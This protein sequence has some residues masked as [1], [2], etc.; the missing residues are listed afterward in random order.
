MIKDDTHNS[1]KKF[2]TGKSK[3]KIHKS[4]NKSV[5]KMSDVRCYNCGKQ[6]HFAKNCKEQCPK[7]NCDLWNPVDRKK[8]ARKVM[9]V[10]EKTS[11]SD[12]DDDGDSHVI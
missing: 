11:N 12:S 2:G 9:K 3:S 5:T 8:L 1:R 4:E 6:G 10:I 7:K